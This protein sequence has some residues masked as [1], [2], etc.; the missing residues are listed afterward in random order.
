[1]I[2]EAMHQVGRDGVISVEESKSLSTEMEIVEGMQFDRG[3]ISPYFVTDA[4]RMICEL[5]KPLILL[6]DKKYANFEVSL[7]VKGKT[8]LMYQVL[9]R[10]FV[11]HDKVAKPKAPVLDL[12]VTY[13]RSKLSTKDVL[14]AKATITNTPSHVTP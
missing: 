14:K 8:A 9:G 6:T 7:E 5:E 13:D 10:H 11:A 12:D 1:M 4:E 2:A 3:Y